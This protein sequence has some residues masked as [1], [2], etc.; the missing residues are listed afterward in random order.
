M[1]SANWRSYRGH[2]IIARKTFLGR[3]RYDVWKDGRLICTHGHIADA[4]IHVDV[5]VKQT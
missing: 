4:E 1:E 3:L 5:R 2:H